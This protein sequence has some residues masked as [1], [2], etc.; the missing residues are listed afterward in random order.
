M[1]I[2]ASWMETVIGA[3]M[4]DALHLLVV[5]VISECLKHIPSNRR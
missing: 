2:K 1:R 3:K 5:V 4:V